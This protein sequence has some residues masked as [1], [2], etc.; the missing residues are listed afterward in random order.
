MEPFG[1]QLEIKLIELIKTNLKAIRPDIDWSQIEFDEDTTGNTVRL[2][3]NDPALCAWLQ[4]T[5]TITRPDPNQP[6]VC[7]PNAFANGKM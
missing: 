7:Y 6:I 1:N 5:I 3:S 2:R 4:Q